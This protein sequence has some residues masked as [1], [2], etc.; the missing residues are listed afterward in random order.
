M[1]KWERALLQIPV[2]KLIFENLCRV[3]EGAELDG[4]EDV[5]QFLGCSSTL[6]GREFDEN[7]TPVFREL[8]RFNLIIAYG[9]PHFLGLDE[10]WSLVWSLDETSAGSS[11]MGGV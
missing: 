6:S 5:W 3:V 2:M 7:E 11:L 8:K 1:V 10:T 4:V 9:N